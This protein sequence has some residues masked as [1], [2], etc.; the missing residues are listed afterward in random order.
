MS[1]KH[2]MRKC[3]SLGVRGGEGHIEIGSFYKVAR[4]QKVKSSP[5]KYF[6]LRKRELD[7]KECVLIITTVTVILA[8]DTQPGRPAYYLH[9]YMYGTLSSRKDI[10]QM[11]SAAG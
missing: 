6:F 3:F 8:T 11:T 7:T 4:S 1:M 5:K 10:E 2:E 9:L